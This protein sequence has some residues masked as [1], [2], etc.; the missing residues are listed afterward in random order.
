MKGAD[1]SAHTKLFRIVETGVIE[2]F[3]QVER[4]HP[5]DGGN[6]SNFYAPVG[7]SV[8]GDGTLIGYSL[9]RD[10]VGGSGYAFVERNRGVVRGGGLAEPMQF[11]GR[12]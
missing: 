2:L 4:R 9:Q 6:T 11:T 10:C 12:A 7:A 8:S 3:V 1:Q 5:E